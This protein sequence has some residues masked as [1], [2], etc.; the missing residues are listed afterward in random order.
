V[1]AAAGGGLGR[2]TVV[3]AGRQV[4]NVQVE[5]CAQKHRARALQV[6]RTRPEPSHKKGLSHEM[7]SASDD[8][9]DL[10]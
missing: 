7:D 3:P 4:G 5:R 10:F 8:I 9:Y 6:R 2:E 1:Y